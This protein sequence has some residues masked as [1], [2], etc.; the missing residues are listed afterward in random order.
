MLPV[1]MVRFFAVAAEFGNTR[2]PYTGPRGRGAHR[3]PPA[4]S[5]GG[6]AISSELNRRRFLAALAAATVGAVGA[7]RLVADAEPRT[8]APAVAAKGATSGP[9]APSAS[10]PPPP[11]GAR[12]PLPGRGA[13]SKIPGQGNLLA[14]T[15]DD[16][17]NS[18]VVRAYTQF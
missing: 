2:I 18:E 10:L 3:K 12:I 6:F 7:A 8:F 5:A 14:L 11:M 13:L 15:V 16:G 4:R 17:V 9:T 1:L